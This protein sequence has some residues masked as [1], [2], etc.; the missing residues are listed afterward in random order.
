MSESDDSSTGPYPEDAADIFDPGEFLRELEEIGHVQLD[1][2]D[3]IDCEID[4]A[5]EDETLSPAAII[6]EILSRA[7]DARRDA[8]LP[9]GKR[10][11]RHALPHP[12][13][14]SP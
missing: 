3:L 10:A 7:A 1:F 2:E 9:N 6:R 4:D 14:P 11:H 5:S 8:P 12:C 13:C